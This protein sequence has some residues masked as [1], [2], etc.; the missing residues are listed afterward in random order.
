MFKE[1]GQDAKEKPYEEVYDLFRDALKDDFSEVE[2]GDRLVVVK[3]LAAHR[4]KMINL[5]LIS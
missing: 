2:G 1:A 4:S 5:R 3:R